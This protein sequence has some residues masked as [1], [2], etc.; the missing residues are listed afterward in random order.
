M[1]NQKLKQLA[2]MTN[3][4][5]VADELLSFATEL[6]EAKI[7]A[8]EKIFM[9]AETANEK[10]LIETKAYKV[11]DAYKK[12]LKEIEAYVQSLSSMKQATYEQT[13]TT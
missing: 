1:N 2:E 4:L 8:L 11:Y 5:K 12:S 7:A 10:K 3:N 9:Y 13:R 6:F